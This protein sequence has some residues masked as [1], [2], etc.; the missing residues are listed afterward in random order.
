MS[1]FALLDQTKEYLD[2]YAEAEWKQSF[3]IKDPATNNFMQNLND[4]AMIIRV[5]YPQDTKPLFAFFWIY[6]M[7]DARMLIEFI[8]E[9]LR[10]ETHEIIFDRDIKL[11]YD[12]DLELAHTAMDELIKYYERQSGE[13]LNTRDL[14]RHLVHLYFDATIDSMREHNVPLLQL[15]N[16]DMMYSTRNR[17]I[18]SDVYKISIHLIT[19]IACSIEQCRAVVED[20]K[21]RIL[22]L[23]YLHDHRQLLCDAIDVQPYHYL[24]SLSIVGGYK[25]VNGIEYVNAIQQKFQWYDGEEFISKTSA[26]SLRPNLS[27]Y[28]TAQSYQSNSQATVSPEFISIVFNNLSNIECYDPLDWDIDLATIKGH[29]AILR[30]C[31]P[32]HCDICDRQHDT[33]NTLLIVF[34]EERRIG[35]WKCIHARQEKSIV[36]YRE[37]DSR[38]EQFAKQVQKTNTVDSDEQIPQE[39]Y[40]DTNKTVQESPQT[41]V[42]DA[43]SDDESDLS[44]ETNESYDELDDE[45]DTKPLSI[46][47]T[48]LDVL[49]ARIKANIPQDKSYVEHE[50]AQPEPIAIPIRY[51][52]DD[53]TNIKPESELPELEEAEPSKSE[54]IPIANNDCESDSESVVDDN[55]GYD[56]DGAKH[57]H[58]RFLEE[59]RGTITATGALYYPPKDVFVI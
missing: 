55:D 24:G 33:D 53:T 57:E 44:M 48:V 52:V 6:S 30:R 36:F 7:T 42:I 26:N 23:D 21:T 45:S 32:S 46:N 27:K 19:N 47:P 22:Q 4:L 51:G 2:N 15:E 20:V 14:S 40:E 18:D 29:T 37:D 38:V 11:F 5:G 16:V 56:S 49:E 10:L 13:K 28:H 41:Q 43:E 1:A 17:P 25:T 50:P 8:H 58:K 59:S 39:S 12:I 31:R 9:A 34:N 54:S 35:A 3:R